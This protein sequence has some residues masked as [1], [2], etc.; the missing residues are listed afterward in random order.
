MSLNC[1][2]M[3]NIHPTCVL[4][5][6]SKR[7]HVACTLVTAYGATCSPKKKIEEGNVVLQAQA[8]AITTQHMV[9]QPALLNLHIRT[10]SSLQSAAAFLEAIAMPS[11][12]PSPAAG[13]LP[14]GLVA[15]LLALPPPA[16]KTL[17]YG[18]AGEF[19]E[20]IEERRGREEGEGGLIMPRK[21]GAV[22]PSEET[23]KASTTQP[24]S[25]SHT[26][27]DPSLLPSLPRTQ[28]SATRPT[29]SSRPS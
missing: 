14:P 3:I 23:K 21:P 18:T 26:L 2:V 12:T 6:G 29:C 13:A 27:L 7:P 10:A 17:A 20:W 5:W 25:H 19:C 8:H 22:V 11:S 28:A 4:D 15:A 9:S 16:G 1:K 24:S